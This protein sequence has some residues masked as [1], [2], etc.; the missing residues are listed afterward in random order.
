MGGSL[1]N[2]VVLLNNQIR[3][4]KPKF[5]VKRAA[6]LL[7]HDSDSLNLLGDFITYY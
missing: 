4:V 3:R 6:G 1:T 2:A 5:R 7:F